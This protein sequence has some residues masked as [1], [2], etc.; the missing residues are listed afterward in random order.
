M[1]NNW[2]IVYRNA[3]TGEP[4]TLPAVT[5]SKKRYLIFKCG[6]IFEGIHVIPSYANLTNVIHE[7]ACTNVGE[8]GFEYIAPS[9]ELDFVQEGKLANQMG[10]DLEGYPEQAAYDPSSP[11]ATSGALHVAAQVYY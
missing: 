2:D 9:M 6:D 5:Q 10:I 8:E 7:V 4:D 1:D 3:E 11:T